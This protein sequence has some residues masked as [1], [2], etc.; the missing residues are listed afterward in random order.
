VHKKFQLFMKALQRVPADLWK[1]TGLS[2]VHIR[3]PFFHGKFC[4]TP[5]HNLWNS[6]PLLSVKTLHS[7][8][9]RRCCINW[10]HFKV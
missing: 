5:R 4:Q 9:S 6:V 1:S 3:G 2:T 7:A 8:A 10:Q